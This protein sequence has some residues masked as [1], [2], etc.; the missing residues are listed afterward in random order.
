M[1]VVR[2]HSHGIYIGAGCDACGRS[3]LA[4]LLTESK[5]FSELVQLGEMTS[6]FMGMELRHLR[7]VIPGQLDYHFFPQAFDPVPNFKIQTYVHRQML[8]RQCLAML[9]K[10]KGPQP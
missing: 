8:C 10:Q 2:R 4:H 7:T 9:P 3:R 6:K 1:I 5:S